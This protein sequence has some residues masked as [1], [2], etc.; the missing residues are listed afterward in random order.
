MRELQAFKVR[1]SGRGHAS[2]AGAGAR[3]Y[4]VVAVALVV[5]WRAI[6]R[7]LAGS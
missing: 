3:D 4:L 7:R 6:G 2:F 1:F 5:W